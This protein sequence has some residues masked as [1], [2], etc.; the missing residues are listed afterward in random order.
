M[1]LWSFVGCLCRVFFDFLKM[2]NIEIDYVQ[3]EIKCSANRY[4]GIL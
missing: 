1:N 3:M 2:E 4:G